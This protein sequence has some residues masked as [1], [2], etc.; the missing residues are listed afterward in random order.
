M[1]GKKRGGERI[2]KDKR[3]DPGIKEINFPLFS[4][5]EGGKKIKGGDQNGNKKK[6]SKRLKNKIA[7]A[8]EINVHLDRALQSSLQ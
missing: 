5:G 6:Q 1:G 8:I 4:H 3:E 7:K 2:K